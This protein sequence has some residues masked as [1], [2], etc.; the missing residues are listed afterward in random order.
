MTYCVHLDEGY[1]SKVYRAERPFAFICDCSWQLAAAFCGHL[2][3]RL[4]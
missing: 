3:F 2:R 4:T 1:K